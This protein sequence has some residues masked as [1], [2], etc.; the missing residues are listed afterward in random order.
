MRL[1]FVIAFELLFNSINTQGTFFMSFS[2]YN[3][4]CRSFFKKLHFSKCITH[5]FVTNPGLSRMIPCSAKFFASP[6]EAR[7]FPDFDPFKTDL[8]IQRFFF[9]YHFFNSTYSHIGVRCFSSHCKSFDQK[10]VRLRGWQGF[11]RG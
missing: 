10:V 2:I 1:I 11:G 4:F 3:F 9:H 7:S 5:C 8:L 6:L